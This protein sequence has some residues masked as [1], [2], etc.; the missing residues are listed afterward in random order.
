MGKVIRVGVIG[1]NGKMGA[2]V[3]AAVQSDTQCELVAAI[4]VEDSLEELTKARCEVVV[5]FTNPHVVMDNLAFV[6]N[7][8]LIAL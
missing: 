7:M 2:A 3:V 1:A 4:D 6:S 5:D 8:E